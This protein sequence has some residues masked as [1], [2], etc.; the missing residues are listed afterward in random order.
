M[1]YISTDYVF[2]GKKTIW[3]PYSELE[4]PNPLNVYGKT[5]REGELA[6]LRNPKTFVLRTAWVFGINGNNFVKT[7][8]GLAENHDE[9]KVVKDQIG[10]PTYTVDL[11]KVICDMLDT[12]KY[13]IYHV[14]NEGYC[15]WAEFA[16]YILRKT[17]TRV[18][19][20]TT[21]EYNGPRYAAAK[22][23]GITL[24]IAERPMN[25]GLDRVKL[26][27]NGFSMTPHWKDATDRFMAEYETY[28]KILK[29]S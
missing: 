3:T 12:D 6:A 19:P 18:I 28:Q 21:D 4:E 11:A 23:K 15:S 25:S 22:A 8:L 5:K 13:G 17:N 1:V 2:D 9:I 20:V 16:A 7:M 29:A 14:T 26:V 27:R 24:T 10:T